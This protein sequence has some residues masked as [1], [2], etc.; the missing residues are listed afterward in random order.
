MW[1]AE[2]VR[3]RL[4]A[5]GAAAALLLAAWFSLAPFDDRRV[6]CSGPLFGADPPANVSITPGTCSDMASDRLMIAG[7]FLV[8]AVVLGVGVVVDRR[9]PASR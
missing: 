5:V 9:A 2:R 6:R 7:G 1:D 8:A 3:R 4:L